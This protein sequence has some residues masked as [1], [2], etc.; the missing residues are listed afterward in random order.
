MV[1]FPNVFISEHFSYLLCQN[2]YSSERSNRFIARYIKD[3]GSFQQLVANC[4]SD[5]SS[6]RQ[7]DFII[8]T[9]GWKNFRDSLASIFI[10]YTRER[11]FPSKI[12]THS[13]QELV[14]FDGKIAHY[15]TSGSSRG[16]LLALF[17]K[18]SQIHLEGEGKINRAVKLQIPDF[19]LSLLKKAQ[20]KVVKVDWIIL[21]LWHFTDYIGVEELGQLL[22]Q[23]IDFK[24]LLEHLRVEQRD[25]LYSNILT[26]S[27]AINDPDFFQIGVFS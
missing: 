24:A 23:R 12:N 5:M 16:F 9:L 18:L 10:H 6:K 17:L 8:K 20:I 27:Y 25:E 2:L 21:L 1:E 11:K 15:T 22:D 26:Y 14:E 19:V 13:S 4:F 7:I 3:H